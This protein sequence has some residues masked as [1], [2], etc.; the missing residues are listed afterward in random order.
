MKPVSIPVDDRL[1]RFLHD[2]HA[3]EVPAGASVVV[4]PPAVDVQWFVENPTMNPSNESIWTVL[5][6]PERRDATRSQIRAARREVAELRAHHERLVRMAH[7]TAVTSKLMR[8]A[9]PYETAEDASKAQQCKSIIDQ[10]R[11][12]EGAL[13]RIWAMGRKRSL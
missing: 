8:D 2:A 7:K 13:D 9:L 6:D 12:T 11:A 10:L 4:L 1:K 3:I 5:A